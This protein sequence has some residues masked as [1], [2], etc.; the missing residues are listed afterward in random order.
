MTDLSGRVVIVTGAAS[1]IGPHYVAALA[2]A[3]ARV[4]IG[5]IADGTSVAN[6]INDSVASDAVMF[7]ELDVSD[8]ES[9][10]AFFVG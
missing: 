6:A 3:G 9:V 8:E 1:G 2:E 4:A 10:S 5:D 7:K